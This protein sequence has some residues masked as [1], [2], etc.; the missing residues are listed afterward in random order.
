MPSSRKPRAQR[1]HHGDLPAEVLR[2]TARVIE[3]RG[4]VEFSMREIAELAGVTHPAL[5]KHFADKRALLA[6]IAL[7]G[8]SMLARAVAVDVDRSAGRARTAKD[9]ASVYV[10]FAL[11]HPAHFRVMFG[12]RLNRDDRYPDLEQA[13]VASYVQL[14]EAMGGSAA[15]TLEEQRKAHDS[16]YALWSMVHGYAMLV[17]DDRIAGLRADRRKADAK[18]HVRRLVT[19]LAQSFET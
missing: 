3:E 8:H 2:A 9:V 6:R 12:P 16:S 11:D 15:A 14:Y 10:E 13:V 17:L 19:P 7:E 18:S 1:Y 4:G 5:Y